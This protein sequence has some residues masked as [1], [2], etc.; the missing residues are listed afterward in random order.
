MFSSISG[1]TSRVLEGFRLG[2]RAIEPNKSRLTFFRM[3]VR[4]GSPSSLEEWTV[5]VVVVVVVVLVDFDDE[6]NCRA[7]PAISAWGSFF[8][9]GVFA[10]VASPNPPALNNVGLDSVRSSSSVILS[11]S[12]A[13]R[14]FFWCLGDRLGEVASMG[15]EGGGER[16]ETL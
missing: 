15:D 3:G 10:G 11:S 14:A 12:N 8:L 6:N 9:R 2:V 13:K 5:F 1:S 7:E 16:V 4:G